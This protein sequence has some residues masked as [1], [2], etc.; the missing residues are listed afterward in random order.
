MATTKIAA[1]KTTST[2]AA[3]SNDLLGV[4]SEIPASD[5]WAQAK[6]LLGNPSP[7]TVTQELTVDGLSAADIKSFL[8]GKESVS[9]LIA[10]QKSYQLPNGSNVD[11]STVGGFITALTSVSTWVRV[12]EVLAGVVLLIMALHQLASVASG[13]SQGK[14]STRIIP[15]PV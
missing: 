7:A 11:I 5:T 14:T 3:S 6:G 15:L 10:K 2:A 1:K 12:L 4:L 13:S 8:A 9:A